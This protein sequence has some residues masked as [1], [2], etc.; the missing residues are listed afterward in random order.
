MK[1]RES[2][3]LYRC[4]HAV[5]TRLLHMAFWMRKTKHLKQGGKRLEVLPSSCED[6]NLS[7]G[8]TCLSLS[9]D[10]YSELKFPSECLLRSLKVFCCLSALL[11]VLLSAPAE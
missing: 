3:D 4:N 10:V 1:I 2:I 5:A 6:S 8:T 11:S 7:T 9:M